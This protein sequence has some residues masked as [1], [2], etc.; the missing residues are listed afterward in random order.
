MTIAKY[1]TAIS[2]MAV[3]VILATMVM[4][5]PYVSSGG[6]GGGSSSSSRRRRRRRRRRRS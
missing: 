1:G 3:C 5:A 4:T 6:G 2:Y